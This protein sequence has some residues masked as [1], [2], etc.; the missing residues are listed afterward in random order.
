MYK[1]YNWFLIISIRIL[2]YQNIYKTKN[3]LNFVRRAINYKLYISNCNSPQ[4]YADSKR[5]I[6]QRLTSLKWITSIWVK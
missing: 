2:S 5:F 1:N 4:Q 3:K 6:I